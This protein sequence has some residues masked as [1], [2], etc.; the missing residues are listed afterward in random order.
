MKFFGLLC[1]F[2][3]FVNSISCLGEKGE[4]VDSWTILKAPATADSFLYAAELNT[5]YPPSYS[6]NDTSQGG[7]SN[8]LKQLW[9]SDVSYILFNDE[10]PFSTSYNFSFGHTKGLLALD[11]NTGFWI[12]HSIPQFPVGPAETNEYMGLL[13]NAYTFGQNAFCISISAQTADLLAYAFHLNYPN[14]YESYLTDEVKSRYSNITSLTQGQ[15]STSS[16][17]GYHPITSVKGKSHIVF[18]KTSEWNNDLWSACVAPHLQTN[19]SVESWLRGSEIGPSCHSYEV[20][21]VKYVSFPNFQSW[22]E[23][24][25]H[26]K[27]ATSQDGT[28]TCHGDINRMTTQFV[29][30]GGG[31]CYKG[32]TNL[33]NAI[34]R[35]TSC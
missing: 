3:T 6:L 32:N 28:W 8:T 1:S 17:C 16:I 25:D 31:I 19:L 14:I 11:Q 20:T 21:D 10:P 13:H 35:Q 27:W 4:F 7:L 12:Q 9:I 2:F 23:F 15:Y 22:S 33:F 26:S 30:G 29:R 24:N 18:S 34:T 5:L